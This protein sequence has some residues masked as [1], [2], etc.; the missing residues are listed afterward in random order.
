MH[1]PQFLLIGIYLR[2]HGDV[3]MHEGSIESPKFIIRLGKNVFK[4]PTQFD[5]TSSFV[6]GTMYSKIDKSRL[7]LCSQVDRGVIQ[8]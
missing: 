2:F 4:F 1:F 8:G 6:M 3:M 5:K 7:V